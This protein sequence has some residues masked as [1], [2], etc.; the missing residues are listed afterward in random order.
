MGV[1]GPVG[2]EQTKEHYQKYLKRY[3]KDIL[4]LDVSDLDDSSD[5]DSDT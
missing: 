4:G 5:V 1:S 3:L 2:H